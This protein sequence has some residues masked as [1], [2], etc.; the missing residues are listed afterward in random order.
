MLLAI[1]GFATHLWW[2]RWC[3]YYY[4]Y[5]VSQGFKLKEGDQKDMSTE[6]GTKKE[7]SAE[8]KTE[9]I[10]PHHIISIGSTTAE[11]IEIVFL[12]I[13]DLILKYTFY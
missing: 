12:P 4:T 9:A 8:Y 3:T 2:V 6:N 10:F 5:T 13:D 1:T 11:T 7:L